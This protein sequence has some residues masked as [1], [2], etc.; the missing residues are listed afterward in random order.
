MV[1][2]FCAKEKRVTWLTTEEKLLVWLHCLIK[3]IN[4]TASDDNDFLNNVILLLLLRKTCQMENYN[5]L[6][7]QIFIHVIRHIC[8]G[9]KNQTHNKL[10]QK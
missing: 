3:K 10:F 8:F 6:Q 9:I 7:S 4:L 5:I 1:S 2:A